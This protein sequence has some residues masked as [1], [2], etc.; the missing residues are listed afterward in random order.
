MTNP[1]RCVP[2]FMTSPLGRVPTQECTFRTMT[3]PARLGITLN[4]DQPT[5]VWK[6]PQFKTLKSSVLT[7]VGNEAYAIPGANYAECRA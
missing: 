4:A 2:T 7:S 6:R 3:A 5:I 1:R